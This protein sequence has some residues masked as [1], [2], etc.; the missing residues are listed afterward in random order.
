[1][2]KRCFIQVSLL[3]QQVFISHWRDWEQVDVLTNVTF[4]SFVSKQ[5]VEP[6]KGDEKLPC[7][8]SSSGLKSSLQKSWVEGVGKAAYIKGMHHVPQTEILTYDLLKKVVSRRQKTAVLSWSS[9][10]MWKLLRVEE[11]LFITIKEKGFVE[12][13]R[14]LEWLTRQN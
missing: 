4:W 12:G 3:R 10:L 13:V 7:S 9:L 6:C 14:S 5:R 8:S 2:D 11:N 1:M